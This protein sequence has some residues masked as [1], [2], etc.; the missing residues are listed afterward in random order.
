MPGSELPSK[1]EVPEV[2]SLLATS[3]RPG[4]EEGT[5]HVVSRH[6]AITNSIVP[7]DGVGRAEARP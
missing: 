1:K 4:V 6:Y 2:L 7:G 5:P 3:R